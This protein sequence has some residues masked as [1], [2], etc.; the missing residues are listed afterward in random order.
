MCLSFLFY[1][2][3]KSHH[4]CSNNFWLL[5]YYNKIE[6]YRTVFCFLL[7]THD[8]SSKQS[9]H[10]FFRHIFFIARLFLIL[11]LLHGN[12]DVLWIKII[13]FFRLFFQLNWYAI[14]IAMSFE[15]AFA[16]WALFYHIKNKINDT[17]SYCPFRECFA[18]GEE[19]SGEN[20][21]NSA[22][23][24]NSRIKVNEMRNCGKTEQ[25]KN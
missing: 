6:R 3:T 7:L 20:K 19:R 10:I 16:N 9:S 15:H 23:Q 4:I 18:L 14:G 12:M 11:K 2:P 25:I 21:V 24:E 5:D 8:T 13:F 22:T 17:V 1:N